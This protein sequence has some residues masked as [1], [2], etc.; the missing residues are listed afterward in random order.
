MKIDF[1]STVHK[2]R[3]TLGILVGLLPILC[4]LFGFMSCTWGGNGWLV[5]GSVSETYWSN[6]KI[7]MIIILGLSA[8]FLF[9][10]QGYDLGDRAFTLIAAIGCIGVAAF[11]CANPIAKETY[12]GLFSLPAN[13]CNYIHQG[14]SIVTFVS[15]SLM[16]LTQFTKGKD[17]KRNIVYYV[18]GSIMLAS[19]VCL[20]LTAFNIIPYFNYNA[21][22]YEF[23]I[24][25]AFAAGF[26][27]KSKFVIQKLFKK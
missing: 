6:H 7:I 12:Q 16:L 3:F 2:Q 19:I 27:V 9:T 10:Y 18:C 17:K 23:I 24:L 11:P 21:M 22:V 13:I 15:L 20:I 25:E 5:L 26:L 4:V 1:E 8:F 14:V